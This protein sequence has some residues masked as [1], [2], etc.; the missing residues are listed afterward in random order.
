MD[1]LGKGAALAITDSDI[2]ALADE[3]KVHPADLE[4]IAEVE[5]SGF[6][7]FP[8]GRIKIL[9]EKHKFYKYI[10][11]GK[12]A[13]AVRLGLARKEF[14]KPKDGGYKDQPDANSRY[15]ILVEAARL[16]QFAAFMS[17]SMG[18]FQ[19]M[20]FN[21]KTC[22]FVSPLEMFNA[23]CQSEAHQLRAFSA[24]LKAENL[25]GAIQ[26]RDF[27]TVEQG[28]NGGALNGEYA[29]KMLKAS[30]ALRNGKW[31]DYKPGSLDNVPV[32][33]PRPVEPELDWKN[34]VVT[35]KDSSNIW[36]AIAR[37]IAAFLK[38]WKK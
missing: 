7:W 28:Y 35:T 17:I 16:D 15:A 38:G 3:L 1:V 8:D 22:G 37:L 12:R 19:I 4:A 5:S 14:I 36:V 27:A 18:R 13:E 20:G 26:R 9:F 2:A 32:P 23:F 10:A 34:P 31:K 33:L 25:I 24:F 21:Y 30:N 6:G 11:S 29:S